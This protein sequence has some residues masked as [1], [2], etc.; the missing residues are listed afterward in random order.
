MKRYLKFWL[1]LT[2]SLLTLTAGINLIVDPYGLFR[3]VDS[4]GFNQIKPTAGKHG[5]MGKA[6]QVLLIR[7]HGLILG[8][9]RA[10]VGFD[11]THQA[12]APD[13]RPVYDLALPGTD[14]YDSVMYL[15]HVL[16]NQKANPP[17]L[18][19]WGIDFMDFLV[20]AKASR[21]H[22]K[23]GQQD[24]RL[25]TNED[26]TRNP[27][28][29]FQVMKDYAAST[30]TLRALSDSIATL[31]AQHQ[32]YPED[33]SS[34]GSNP[35]R[36]YIKITADEGAW[37]VFRQRDLANTQSFLRRP[38]DIFDENG[39]SSP[40]LDDLRQVIRL[41]R[42]HGIQLH[43]VIYPYHAHLLEVFRLTGHWPAFEAWK[44]A[45]LHVAYGEAVAR[46][47]PPVPLWDFSEFDAYTEEPVPPR[48]DRKATMKWYW[49][50]GHFK[51]ELGDLVL[52]RVL[53]APGAPEG[54]GTLLTPTNIE[55]QLAS[56][57]KGEREYR[58]SH[59]S[60][61]NGL[62]TLATRLGAQGGR[63]SSLTE[64]AFEGS[65]P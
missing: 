6:Y 41:C 35:M 46:G 19:V 2:A 54:F 37:S 59:A 7:P 17:R 10:E 33:L 3:L 5:R 42:E 26:G 49:E 31:V 25:L 43:L 64:P 45:V 40:P 8:N 24:S 16:E 58:S 56:V 4:A 9:S 52:D 27:G 60:E 1:I 55:S 50:A 48:G 18:V 62:E 11:P 39:A 14:T 23:A 61:V 36:D 13:V 32:A 30:F 12:W 15:R 57:R 44:R 20:D 21:P 63:N 65:M 53:S 38:R 29:A 28:R 22:R 34:L 47:L 51:R